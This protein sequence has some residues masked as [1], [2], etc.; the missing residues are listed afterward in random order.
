MEP[1]QEKSEQA[2]WRWKPQMRNKRFTILPAA[3]AYLSLPI[4][5]EVDG[6]G[7]CLSERKIM[8]TDHDL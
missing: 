2:S 8:H 1:E 3:L 7:L 6:F 4:H 5:D